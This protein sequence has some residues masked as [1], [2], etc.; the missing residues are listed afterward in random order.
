MSAF[1]DGCDR[2]R[3]FLHFEFKTDSG[4]SGH[5][6]SGLLHYLYIDSLNHS[7]GFSRHYIDLDAGFHGN[8]LR[9]RLRRSEGSGEMTV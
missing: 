7:T 9:Q 3:I 4:F 8:Q 1:T 6:L 5:C 2:R